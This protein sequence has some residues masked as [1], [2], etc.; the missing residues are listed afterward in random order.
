MSVQPEW[1]FET[2]DYA[3]TPVVLSQSTWQSKAGNDEPGTHP[4]IHDYLVDVRA[5]I[6]SPT[7]VFQSTRDERSRIFYRLGAGRGEF[8]GKH[9]VVVVKY[10]QEGTGQRGYVG[11]M[12]LSRAVYSRGELLWPRSARISQ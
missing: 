8:A 1:V 10:V 2:T 9:V 3:G 4:E 5:A 12:Y 11:T 7:L 6:E